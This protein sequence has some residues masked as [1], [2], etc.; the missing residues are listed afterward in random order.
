MD[1]RLCTVVIVEKDSK[2]LVGVIAW[3]CDLRWSDSPWDAWNTRDAI[4][5]GMVAEK[6]HGRRMLFNPV[7]KQLKEMEH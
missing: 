2:Y 4:V 1:I 3:S 6:V 7:A 5:A